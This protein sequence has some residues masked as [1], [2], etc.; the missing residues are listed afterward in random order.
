MCQVCEESVEYFVTLS[1]NGDVTK[2]YIICINCYERDL[3]QTK[4]KTKEPIT[5]TGS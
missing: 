2:Y 3:W 5:R 4:I 1:L